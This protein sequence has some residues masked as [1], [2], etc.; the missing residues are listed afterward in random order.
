MHAVSAR[1][2]VRGEGRNR[3]LQVEYKKRRR[4]FRPTP[5]NFLSISL[6]TGCNY[7]ATAARDQA[8]QTKPQQ[9]DGS[10]FRDTR[11]VYMR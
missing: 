3:Y 10:G 7:L 6:R 2:S 4:T 11:Q 5:V 1:I 9:S 8:Q